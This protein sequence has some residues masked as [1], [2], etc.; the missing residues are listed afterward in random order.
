[1]SRRR[2]TLFA[3]FLLLGLATA[4]APAA[5]AHWSATGSGFGSGLVDTMTAANQ[6]STSVAAP[7]VTVSWAQNTVGGQYL[8]AIGGEYEIRRYPASGGSAVTPNGACG[9][10]VSGASATLN[11]IETPTPPGEWVY[12]VEPVLHGWSGAEGPASAMTS[13]SPA[14]PT[15]FVAD[16]A[17]AGAIALSWSAS[18]GATGYNIFRSTTSGVFNYASPLNGGTPVSGT[19]YNDTTAVSGTT[20]YYVIRALVIGGG[21]VQIQSPS[22]AQDSAISDATVPTGVT[23]VDPGTP[24]RGSINFSGTASDT[25]TGVSTITFEYKLSSGSTW[26][27]GCVD[28]VTPFSCA[29]DTMTIADGLYDFRSVARDFAGNMTASTPVT[30]RRID[31]TAPTALLTN[32]GANLRLTVT[33]SGSSGDA[34]SGVIATTIERRLVGGGAWTTTCSSATT[35]VSC[36]FNTTTV[37]DGNY[38]LRTSSTDLAGNIGYSTVLTP[39]RIDNTRPTAANIQTIN[40]GTL[41]RPE[42]GDQLVFTFSENMN[43]ATILAGFTGASINVT[44]RINNTGGNDRLRVYNAA[45]TTETALG[46]VRLAGNYVSADRIF[47]AST[48]VM[49]G[50][51]LTVTL[52]AAS[53]TVNTDTGNAALNWRPVTTPL[54]LAGNQMMNT[55]CV[56]PGAADPNF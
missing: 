21:S 55:A 42:A 29:F 34:G 41:G 48:M 1:M 9:T 13:V 24:L 18:S 35:T 40:A 44:V 52:G 45:N 19:T 53:G 5:S 36:A 27:T 2:L 4:L 51:T 31:N 30:S 46:E 10:P 7:A 12:T 33:L 26:A 49:S 23:I 37:I 39:V 50:S 20:Y 6:P 28:T 56:E 25:I 17:P 15:S 32:P 16:S 54:D 38:E 11:C 8:G 47:T 3:A 43:P 22:T 14:V